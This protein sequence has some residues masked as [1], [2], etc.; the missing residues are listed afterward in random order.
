MPGVLYPLTCLCY[1]SWSRWGRRLSQGE[2]VRLAGVRKGDK[3]AYSRYSSISTVEAGSP[4]T[5]RL[6]TRLFRARKWTSS[7]ST[8]ASTPLPSSRFPISHIRRT[9]PSTQASFRWVKAHIEFF[10]GDPSKDKVHREGTGVVSVELHLVASQQPLFATFASAAGRDTGDIKARP[11]CSEKNLRLARAACTRSVSRW[12]YNTFISPCSGRKSLSVIRPQGK[13][14][15][16]SLIVG[17]TFDET[18]TGG[19]DVAAMLKDS[20]L[21]L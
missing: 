19:S 16:V 5:G 15:R 3:R 12:S 20:F 18:V 4:R 14:V 9:A 8:I 13:F 17:A 10:G 11:A 1:R 6:I 2:R 7:P 21:S